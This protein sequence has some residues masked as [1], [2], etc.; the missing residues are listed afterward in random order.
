MLNLNWNYHSSWSLNSISIKKNPSFL[1]DWLFPRLGWEMCK[2]SRGDFSFPE[3]RKD[4]NTKRG[5]S[6]G[7][8]RYSDGV[9]CKQ[10]LDRFSIEK[11]NDCDYKVLNK[12][13]SRRSAVKKK[14]RNFCHQLLSLK[15]V[16]KVKAFGICLA[17]L[18]ETIGYLLLIRKISSSLFNKEWLLIHILNKEKG[19]TV[20][21]KTE[22]LFSTNNSEMT[23]PKIIEGRYRHYMKG[24]WGKSIYSSVLKY[25]SPGYLL[26]CTKEIWRSPL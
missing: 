21:P 17:F 9:S 15:F 18:G 25:C 10:T 22:N 1:E 6:K 7:Q 2:M 13:I 23:D 19:K 4:L 8:R 11:N 16:T 3:S 20:L 14:E 12:K 26:I 5:L 24:L